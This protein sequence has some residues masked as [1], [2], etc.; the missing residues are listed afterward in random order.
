MEEWKDGSV[1]PIFH[2]SILPLIKSVKLFLKHADIKKNRLLSLNSQR[3]K[4]NHYGKWTGQCS[5]GSSCSNSLL[6][7]AH[8]KLSCV[9]RHVSNFLENNLTL[10]K[11]GRME[12]W[13]EFLP[14]FHPSILPLTKCVKRFL[15][16]ADNGIKTRFHWTKTR[17]LLLL[18]NRVPQDTDLFNLNLN[19]I[20]IG[21]FFM[22]VSHAGRRTC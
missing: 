17:Y 8:R 18:N 21:E 3:Y 20:A 22:G 13:E 6:W 14:F 19:D 1:L 4:A 12:G 11:D 9:C 2:P 10:W 7:P 15:K 5:A 16:H